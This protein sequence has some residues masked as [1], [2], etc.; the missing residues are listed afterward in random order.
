MLNNA[1]CSFKKFY[2]A[3]GYTDLRRGVEGLASIVKLQFHLDPYARNTLFLFCGKR[4]DRIKALLWE[5]D[6]F[7]L[8][9]K[10]LYCGAFQRPRSA[11]EAREISPDQYR[12]LMQGLEIIAKHPMKNNF[13]LT[14]ILTI[15]GTGDPGLLRGQEELADDRYDQ[16]S[17]N[18]CDD[19]QHRR[20]SKS[21]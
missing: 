11:D 21:E 8:L 5:G 18:L 17:Q 20:S 3:T 6:G 2:I 15:S 7:L 10:R 13:L 4:T 19:I 1:A 9:Y 16:W 12:M 14:T